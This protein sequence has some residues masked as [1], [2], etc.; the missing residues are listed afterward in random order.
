MKNNRIAR[1]IFAVIFLAGFGVYIYLTYPL[2]T[3]SGDIESW[4]EAGG[5]HDEGWGEAIQVT[6]QTQG[7]SSAAPAET[8]PEVTEETPE[9]TAVD[10]ESPEGRAAALGLPAPPD[11][12]IN[13]WQYV[14]VNAA[15]PL[16]PQD[17]APAE[18]SYLNM[19]ASETDIQNVYN[20]Y[21][22]PIDSRIAQALLD[23]ALGCK[24]AGNEV[25]LSSGYRSYSEQ[26][27]LFQR[28]VGQGYSEDV[29]KTIVA[30]PGTSEH[31]TGLCCDITDHYRETK[32]SS[33]EST[34]TYQ[35]LC[36]HCAEYGF[37]VRYPADK[38]GDADSVTGVIYEP[39]HFRYVGTDAAAYMME[40]GL[41]LEEFTALYAGQA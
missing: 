19:T 10:P 6:D 24:E 7:E 40:N 20:E 32:D 4:G 41:C 31:Q 18:L 33:L 5:L 12:D 11:I 37:V 2:H 22:C 23:F 38:S 9:E 14:L 35:W 28:K 25:Y 30:Y 13:Q 29:A 36:A 8:E 26:M 3:T 21:R 34:A 17:Y 16:E 27:T 15:T 39:W 1:I